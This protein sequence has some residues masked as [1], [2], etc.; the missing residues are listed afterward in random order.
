MSI[1]KATN[2]SC[3]AIAIPSEE[4]NKRAVE[5]TR[6]R[7]FG[8]LSA[9]T[10][11]KGVV[12]SPVRPKARV[13]APRAALLPS[14]FFARAPRAIICANIARENRYPPSQSLRNA[15][16]ESASKVPPTSSEE[17]YKKALR[18]RT[19]PLS[20]LVA[21]RPYAFKAAE[22]LRGRCIS[23]L[24]PSSSWILRRLASSSSS[25]SR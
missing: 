8:N 18:S 9:A 2:S 16:I 14:R 22:T 23:G 11:P 1:Q 7:R 6:I 25:T 5:I 19:A 12:N 3:T 4:I 17:V 10:P 13:T 21:I 24:Q 15:G 20:A